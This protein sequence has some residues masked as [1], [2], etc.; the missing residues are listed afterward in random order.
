MGRKFRIYKDILTFFR[1]LYGTQ[2]IFLVYWQEQYYQSGKHSFNI[3]SVSGTAERLILSTYLETRSPVP[4]YVYCAERFYH[5][6][7]K[8]KC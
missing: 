7:A 6:Q 5:I 4:F 8:G 3:R 1:H 2:L